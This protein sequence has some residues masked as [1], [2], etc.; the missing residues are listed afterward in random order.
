MKKLSE[1]IPGTI[2]LA[3]SLANSARR[4]QMHLAYGYA[5]DDIWSDLIEMEKV[6][7]QINAQAYNFRMFCGTLY[8]Y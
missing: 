7:S 3:D 6:A 2:E 4:V 8:D 1:V 5:P